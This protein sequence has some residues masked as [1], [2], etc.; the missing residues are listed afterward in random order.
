MS[1]A[2]YS[3]LAFLLLAFVVHW[4]LPQRFRKAFLVATS[5]AFY[6]TWDARFCIL[7]FAV[8]LF[9]WGY[10]QLLARQKSPGRLL[11]LGITI[12]ILPLLYY[13]YTNFALSTIGTLSVAVG[14]DWALEP[15]AI[16]VP[17]GI[18][19]FCFQGVAYLVDVSSGS[20]PIA[21]FCDFILFKGFWPQLIAGPIIR[22]DEMREQ[23]TVPRTLRYENV[24]LGGERIIHGLFKK[25]VVADGVGAIVD[26]AFTE[27]ATPG[28]VD[29]IVG[30]VGF[31][32]Q[33]Y[34]DFGGYSDIAIGSARLFGY[35]FPENFDWPYTAI[36]PQEFWNRWHITLS[37][38]IRDYVFTPLSFAM[39]G[40][41]RLAPLSFVAAMALC[42]LWHGPDW[43]F[44]LWGV[45]HGA[46]LVLN[47]TLLRQFFSP[48]TRRLARLRTFAAWLATFS[49]V[50][51]GWILFRSRSLD[52]AGSMMSAI[53]S[54]RGGLR[55]MIVRENDV[56]LVFIAALFM[57]GAQ[58]LR[59]RVMAI[60]PWL[61][62]KPRIL[63]FARAFLIVVALVLAIVLER[64][65]KAFVY[66]QF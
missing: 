64:D 18:S 46:L 16:V 49:S 19:F 65:S 24:A 23:L 45:W 42:G 25:L 28:L 29:A 30:A 56:I 44:V 51:I 3:Y 14:L 39:R 41:P 34:F 47:R 13:K 22:P 12:E 53:I 55:P 26:A 52:Q 21:K 35:R 20:P 4:S 54:V 1:F 6:A 15:L 50:C 9:S 43:T 11:P 40:V 8:T 2:S 63:R 38:W 66:F 7:L 62:A 10:G 32:L 57:F 58:G 61:T 33:I 27:G 37:S 31:S 48:T 59:N 17:L 36:S 5:Y 60:D